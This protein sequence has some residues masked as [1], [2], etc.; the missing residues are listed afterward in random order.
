M[1]DL[2]SRQINDCHRFSGIQFHICFIFRVKST[3]SLLTKRQVQYV[4]FL[5]GSPTQHSL[6]FSPCGS[7]ARLNTRCF[8]IRHR[9]SFFYV[10]RFLFRS[11][12][13]AI[14]LVLKDLQAV[15]S[16]FERCFTLA[17][18]LCFSGV[19][20][21]IPLICCVELLI[22]HLGW[23]FESIDKLFALIR[24]Y[25]G[26]VGFWLGAQSVF[27]VWS[28]SSVFSQMPSSILA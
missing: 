22:A 24:I 12:F 3:I 8:S 27:R 20:F 6:D 25:P 23:V 11:N 17:L 2:F 26:F 14:S 21:D 19:R 28:S 7:R 9:F 5:T 10:V 18:R 15:G 16:L 1:V 4:A 13:G